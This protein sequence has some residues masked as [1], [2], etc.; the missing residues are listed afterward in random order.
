VG[1]TLVF[2]DRG[3]HLDHCKIFDNDCLDKGGGVYAWTSEVAV[4]HC[5]VFGNSSTSGGG[6][7]VGQSTVRLSNCTFANCYANSHG[8][9]ICSERDATVRIENSIIA[10]SA[11]S[12]GVASDD[13][14]IPELICSNLYG[15][16][17]GDWVGNISDQADINGNF[18]LNPFFCDLPSDDFSI[19]AHSPCS[20][21]LSSCGV[22]VGAHDVNCCADTGSITGIVTESQIAFPGVPVDLYDETGLVAATVSDDSGWYGF[23]DLSC[24]CYWVSIATPL[25]YSVDSDTRQVDIIGLPVED[26][27]TLATQPVAM[28]QRGRGYWMHQ[29]NAL[30]SGKGNAHETYEDMCEYMEL[31]RTHFNDHGLNPINVFEVDLNSGCDDRLEALK[32]TISPRPKSTMVDKA[33]A[34]LTALLLNMVSGKIPQW[35]YISEDDATVSQAITYCNLLITNSD[36]TDD[37]TAKDI[38]EKINEG[39]LIPAEWID[40][41]TPDYSYRQINEVIPSLFSLSQNHPNPFNPTTEISLRLP[42]ATDWKITIYNVAGQKIKQ[43]NGT[44][45][46]GVVT[47]IWDASRQAS[48]IYLYKAEA[49]T[50]SDTKKMLLLK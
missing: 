45:E 38:A 49:G 26:D 34:H 8:A 23:S 24:G 41:S 36:D 20:P 31:I 6:L 29:V 10:F 12:Q 18:S 27:F 30:L 28:S 16:D 39:Q 40:A 33:K 48:G 15:N 46:T 37:E 44:S 25:G 35:A 19:F 4:D 21:G 50:F 42:V 17:G 22:L 32:A 43:F 11:Q 3:E 47:V 1:F 9:G 7:W 5:T 14:S 13:S 2:A